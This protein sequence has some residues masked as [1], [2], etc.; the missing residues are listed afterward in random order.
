MTQTIFKSGFVAVMGRPNVGKSTLVNSLVGQK[1]AAVTP[2]PQ[3]TR[4]R[5]MGILTIEN[6]QVI[7]IDTP[8]VHQPR[9]KLGEN[10]N[11]EALQTLEES[12]LVLFVVDLTSAPTEED[13]ILVD[14]LEKVRKTTPILIVMNKVDLVE[15]E[16]LAERQNLFSNL[17][18]A[19]RFQKVSAVR[20]D[21]L[22]ILLESI[23]DSLKEGEL[24]FPEGQVTDL[25][26]RDIAADLLRESALIFLRDEVPHGIA[27]RIDLFQERP[28]NMTYIEATMFVEK[29][30]HK[31]IVIGQ[32]GEM[33]K[34]ISTAARKEI[35]SVIDRK[36]FLRANVK[37]R[38]NWRNDEKVLR[39]FGYGS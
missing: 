12:D 21:G 27:V 15:P 34:K 38:K 10:M 14:A 31:P 2:R 29:E 8:G 37:V 11:L 35:E 22:E 25:I 20:G 23:L 28:E 1:I 33:L 18:P 39:G 9:Y 5:Q 13:Q 26:E 17:L 36:V 16:F 3:T 7:F 32:N 24:F 6:A 19:A 30:S 4:K